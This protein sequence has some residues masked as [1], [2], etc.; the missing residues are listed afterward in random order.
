[1]KESNVHKALSSP[2]REEIILF[3]GLEKRYLSEIANHIRKTPQTT[4][5]HLS[6]LENNNFIKSS[7]SEGKKYYELINKDILKYIG[8]QKPLPHGYHPKPPHEIILDVKEEL[9]ERMDRI[10]KKLDKILDKMN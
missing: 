6:I 3:L 4:D 10:E 9:N 1:M 2:V 5:F 8:H 7:D